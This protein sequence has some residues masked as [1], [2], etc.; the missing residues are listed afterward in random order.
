MCISPPKFF[1]RAFGAFWA[2]YARLRCQERQR[3]RQSACATAEACATVLFEKE[4]G[5]KGSRD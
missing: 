5:K 2:S 4:K 3:G 1:E